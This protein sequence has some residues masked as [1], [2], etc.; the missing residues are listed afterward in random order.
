MAAIEL[1]HVSYSYGRD[2][3]G[4]LA[5]R[6]ISLT[7]QEGEFVCVVGPSGCGKTTLLRLLAGLDLPTAGE[8]RVNGR[9]VTGPGAD[10][11]IVFQNYPLFPWLT[12]RKNIMFAVQQVRKLDRREAR[13]LADVFLTRV[14]L[15]DA[16]EKYP[17][18]LSGGMR[19]RVAI[20]RSLAIDREILLL[21]E[22]FGALDTRSRSELQDLLERLT[23]GEG[24][25]P[26]TVVLVTHDVHE[27]VFLGDRVLYMEP[28]ELAGEVAVALPRPRRTLGEEERDCLC[29][30]RR[31]LLEM[32][33]K[34]GG[35]E[36]LCGCGLPEDAL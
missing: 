23:R 31:R 25:R 32:F 35:G 36:L 20:A 24:Q 13:E 5:L 12:A 17:F 7:I 19:Q 9:P 6:D 11:A 26:R 18:Q 29:A 8:I 1:E 14:G 34:S 4:A 16:A 22:P 10:C 33:H 15:L 2:G 27:A 28:G 30:L 3:A 21:D